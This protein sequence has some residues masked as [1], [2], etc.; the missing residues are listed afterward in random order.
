MAFALVAAIERFDVRV[1]HR[2]LLSQGALKESPGLRA[3]VSMFALADMVK[4]HGLL[5]LV[6][7]AYRYAS[8]PSL[9]TS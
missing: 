1:L 4:P 5:V 7:S 9:S 2:S 3:L 8:T 6:S